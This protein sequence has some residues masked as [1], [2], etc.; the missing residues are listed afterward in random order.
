MKKPGCRTPS[1]K[2][3]LEERD[4][5]ESIGVAKT[6]LKKT[7]EGNRWEKTGAGGTKVQVV[8]NDMVMN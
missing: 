2:R 6:C 7:G 3:L 1:G 4:A 8:T 5:G